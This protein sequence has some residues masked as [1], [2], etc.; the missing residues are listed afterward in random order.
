MIARLNTIVLSLWN[1]FCSLKLAM[2][3]LISLAV[4]SIIGTVIPQG[5]VPEE[6]LSH[7]GPA[8]VSLYRMLGFFDMYHSWWFILLL[9]A[10]TANLICCS[11]KRLPRIWKIVFQPETIMTQSL[12]STFSSVKTISSQLGILH[13]KEKTELFLQTEFAQP[14]VREVNGSYYLFSQK[15]P[16]C[17]FSVYIVHLSI[18]IIFIGAIIGTQFGFKGYVTIVEGQSIDRIG[19]KSG[20]DIIP[21]FS[22][23]CEKFSVE[24]Y[25]NG[26]PKEF[27][28]ILTVLENG[29]PVPG[30]TNV[31]VIVNEPM[32]YK[33]ITFYQSSYGNAG[34]YFF[35]T[36][37]LE[38]KN[39]TD[40]T[41]DGNTS[42]TLPDG[43]SVHVVDTTPDIAPYAPGLSGA[44]AQLEIHTPAGTTEQVV[45]YANHPELNSTHAQKHGKGPVLHYKGEKQ[46]VYTGLQVAKDPGVWVV[47]AGCGVMIVGIYVA[48]FLSHRRIWVRI[49]KGS[50]TIGGN[51]HKNPAAFNLFFD[52][53]S[54]KYTS[55]ISQGGS[56]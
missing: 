32:T 56:L 44:A 29:K 14:L 15:A 21:G 51:A 45:V 38:G 30:Y 17:R 4:L 53:I 9:Y 18:I 48:F 1:S 2:L 42:A 41:I 54:E 52:R 23:R 37:D 27:K 20:M 49:H 22:V 8:K 36:T 3:L 50:I 12:E 16:W 26:A 25:P 10:L 6:Y 46:A 24:K 39:R 55:Q 5:S 35:F 31:R 47:W 11:I 19:V 40:F 28:S 7:I 13:L 34:K 43:S 33:G